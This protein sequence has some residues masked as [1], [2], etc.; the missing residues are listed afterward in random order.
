MEA[1]EDA[2]DIPINIVLQHVTTGTCDVLDGFVIEEDGSF[3]RTSS[4]E[5]PD[6]E[7]REVSDLVLQESDDKPVPVP[8]GRGHRKK[9]EVKPFGGS[10]AWWE[11]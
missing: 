8:L 3:V 2:S 10:S 9:K 5:D 4:V 11:H 7:P 6:A 1:I